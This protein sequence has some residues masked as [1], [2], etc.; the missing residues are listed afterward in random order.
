ME[1]L[2]HRDYFTEEIGSHKYYSRAWQ[3]AHLTWLSQ[4]DTH[5]ESMTTAHA[6]A[7]L[8]YTLNHNVSSDFATAMAKAVGSP[9]QY[10]QSFRCMYL[11]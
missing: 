4:E 10:Q 9:G 3:K 7:I 1:E 11:H 2:S 6:V 8:V 5:P